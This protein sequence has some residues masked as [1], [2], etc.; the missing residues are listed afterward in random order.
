MTYYLAPSL[1]ALRDEINGRWPKRDKTS[2]GWIGDTSHAARPSDHNPDWT[3]GGVVRATDTDKDGIDVGV[4]IASVL[5]DP[6]VEYVIWDRRIASRNYVD[7]DGRWLWRPYDGSNPHDH[8]IHISIRHTTAAETDTS[9]WLTKTVQEDDM[10]LID[11][12][13]PDKDKA[14]TVGQVL[15]K[16]DR[17]ADAST[18]RDKEILA[19][20]RGTKTAILDAIPDAAT[21]AEVKRLLENLDATISIVVNDPAPKP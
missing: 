5:G 16:L 3:A 10:Q 1:A 20:T 19:A 8:H 15:R 21:K 2:D 4:L 17:F 11:D 7:E 14:V 18:A 9:G 13:Y 12:I 6:R